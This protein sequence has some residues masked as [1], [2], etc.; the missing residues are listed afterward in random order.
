MQQALGLRSAHYEHA[1]Q[2][3]EEL[4]SQFDDNISFT[5]HSLGGGLA[6]AAAIATNRPATTFNAAGLHPNT[7]KNHGGLGSANRLITAHYIK[8]D[9]LSFLQDW[10]PASNAAGVRMPHVYPRQ[11]NPGSLHMYASFYELL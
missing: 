8:G 1:M 6:S 11:S 10:S 9:I 7:V 5:G 3:A 2:F 4:V